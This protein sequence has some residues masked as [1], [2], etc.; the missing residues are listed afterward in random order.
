MKVRITTTASNAKALQVIRYD[1][2]K[3]I[4]LKHIGSAHS[5]QELDELLIL[6]EEWIKDFSGQLSLFP[7]QS[8]NNVLLLNHSTFAGIKYRQFYE[9]IHRLLGVL[10]LKHLPEL[11]NDLVVMRIFEP[12]SKLRSLEL[13]EQFFGIKHLRKTYY[14]IV[15]KC[16]E[17]KGEVEKKIIEFVESG[18]NFNYDIL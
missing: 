7:D 6:P 17:L 18:Y 8:P 9:T 11:L 4:V 13:L 12:A 2:Y 10:G 3:R 15:P 16:I 14:K 5:K 1:N